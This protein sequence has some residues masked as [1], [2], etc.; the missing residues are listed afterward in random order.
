MLRR[1]LLATLI[2][3]APMSAYAENCQP[4]ADAYRVSQRIAAKG[5]E[6]SELKQTSANAFLRHLRDRG[7]PVPL[8]MQP[9]SAIILRAVT[10][11]MFIPVTNGQVCNTI[12]IPTQIWDSYFGR[13][14]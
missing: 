3:L 4:Y 7:V 12:F 1:L 5:A 11:T 9:E 6:L 8:S 13:R 10:V 2:T 14:A